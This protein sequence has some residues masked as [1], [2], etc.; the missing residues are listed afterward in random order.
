[1]AHGAQ[2]QVCVHCETPR[3]EGESGCCIGVERDLF[4]E[5]ASAQSQLLRILDGTTRRHQEIVKNEIIELRY[6]IKDL[7]ESV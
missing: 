2:I 5:I 3:E 1:M 6:K 4:E 7:R